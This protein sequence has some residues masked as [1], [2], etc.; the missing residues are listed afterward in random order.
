MYPN[1]GGRTR[2]KRRTLE[3]AFKRKAVDV[4][5]FG[6]DAEAR[7]RRAGYL[8]QLAVQVAA[9]L[10]DDGSQPTPAGVEAAGGMKTPCRK[11]CAKRIEG[12]VTHDCEPRDNSYVSQS[13]FSSYLRPRNVKKS[14][15]F[16]IL[17]T[18]ELLPRN[19][20]A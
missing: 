2:S 12:Q 18:I 15:L 6:H 13:V 16:A 19:S 5:Q 9:E 10:L 20:C 7:R 3:A 4:V 14:L 1:G 17:Q 11:R 8:A